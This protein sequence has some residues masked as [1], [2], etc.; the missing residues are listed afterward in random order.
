MKKNYS[1]F[2]IL[3]AVLLLVA[4]VGC[5]SKDKG[6]PKELLDRYFSSAI[7]QEYA[8]EDKYDR[9]LGFYCVVSYVTLTQE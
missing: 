4:G 1:L 6:G 9:C 5:Q 2:G 7:K 3:A 8:T